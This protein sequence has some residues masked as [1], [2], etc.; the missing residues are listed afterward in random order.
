AR[1]YGADQNDGVGGF[2][3]FFLLLDEPSVYGLPQAPRT[4][5]RD[6]GP[7]WAIALAAAA[8]LGLA[9]LGAA[10]GGRKR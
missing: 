5:S 8:G 2:G 4:P 3:A 1:L 6:L 10:F 7:T 9:A